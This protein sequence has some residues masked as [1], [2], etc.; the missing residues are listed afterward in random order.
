MSWGPG[1]GS[2]KHVRGEGGSGVTE[3]TVRICRVFRSRPKDRQAKNSRCQ[4]RA[5]WEAGQGH[6]ETAGVT[7]PEGSRTL[8]PGNGLH[9]QAVGSPPE[10]GASRVVF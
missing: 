4:T 7:L 6:Q 10:Q 2:H 8:T 5:V 9:G 3:E 1:K